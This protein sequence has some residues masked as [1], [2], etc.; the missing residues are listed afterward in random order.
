MANQPGTG[1]EDFGRK[2]DETVGKAVPRIEEE[3][4]KIIGYLNDE[5]VPKVRE[6]SSKGLRVA[7]EQLT[8]LAEHLDRTTGDRTSGA[9]QNP[10]DQGQNE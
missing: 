4:K 2:V 7:A 3:L 5:V 6:N 9:R 8:R 1:F 10:P